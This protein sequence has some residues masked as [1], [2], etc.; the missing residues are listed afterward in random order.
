MTIEWINGPHANF[1]LL[2]YIVALMIVL[3][4]VIAPIIKQKQLRKQLLLAQT[5][6]DDGS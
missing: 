6:K 5:F 1:I 3:I 4:I 2:S